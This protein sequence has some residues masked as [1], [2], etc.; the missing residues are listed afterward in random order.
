[1]I[2]PEELSCGEGQSQTW[3]RERFQVVLECPNDPDIRYERD[4][5]PVAGNPTGFTQLLD[6]YPAITAWD[7]TLLVSVTTT[8][9]NVERY[10]PHA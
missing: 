6:V 7:G 10:W 8:I 4:G 5:T 3:D 1:M 9:E 2:V